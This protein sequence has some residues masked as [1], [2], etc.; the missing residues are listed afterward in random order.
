MTV[1]ELSKI[2]SQ[3]PQDATVYTVDGEGLNCCV[4]TSV[5]SH[6]EMSANKSKTKVTLNWNYERS[7]L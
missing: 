3:L 1:N 5:E 4:I 7:V 6:T 2:L